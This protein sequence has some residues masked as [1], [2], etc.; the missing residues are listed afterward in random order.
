MSSWPRSAAAA[1]A[2]L[3]AGHVGAE[4]VLLHNGGVFEGAVERSAEAISVEGQGSLIRL[5][6]ADVAYVADSL[7]AAYEWKRGQMGQGGLT[8]IDHL[9]LADWAIEN[10]L[11]EQAARELLDARQL[12]PQSGRLGLLE[13]RL[14]EVMR[15]EAQDAIAETDAS[16]GPSE[17]P[18]GPLAEALADDPDRPKL[19]DGALEQFTRRIQ[20]VLL[21]SCAATGC[22]GAEPAGGFALDVAPLRGY[23]DARSTERNLFA[24]LRLIDV[25]RPLDSTL[26]TTARGPHAGVSPISGPRRDEML[27][28]IAIWVGSIASYNAP[29]TPTESP[30]V[31]PATAALLPS[32]PASAAA[33]LPTPPAAAQPTSAATPAAANEAS[34]EPD[35]EAIVA[36]A[37]A[38]PPELKHGAQLKRVGPRDE[39][40]PAV[41]NTRYRRPQ[42]DE[43]LE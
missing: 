35:W 42:D 5:R 34:E 9:E 23:G 38:K 13:R 3:T 31:T 17:A 20:P 40:D 32:P 14:D 22:H 18:G 29:P 2:L 25:H 6:S 12:V 30:A 43:P 15:L 24:S 27:E 8:A 37:E 41:F 7:L 10:R 36:A 11:W 1:L 16:T 19:P 4:V 21:N 28:R 33:A 39:F 26:L